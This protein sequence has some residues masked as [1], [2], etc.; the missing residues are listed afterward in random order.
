MVNQVSVI[1]AAD[2]LEVPYDTSDKEQV[3]KVRKK[4][5]RTRADRLAFV[6]AA[7]TTE[8]GRAWF[9]DLL[10]FCHLFKV[11]Y[12]SGDPH[13][14]SFRCGEANVG[15]RVMDDIQTIAPQAYSVMVSENKTRNG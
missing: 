11:P 13:G 5:A 7:M 8:Q 4:A 6:E 1:E 10:N 12:I 15:I 3:N 2:N 14:T 9:Y